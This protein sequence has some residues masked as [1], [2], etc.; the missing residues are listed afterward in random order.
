MIYGLLLKV[1][2]TSEGRVTVLD[3]Q[4]FSNGGA[5]VDL[6]IGVRDVSLSKFQYS[7]TPLHRCVG[8][9]QSNNS[10]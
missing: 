8:S 7:V 5:S 6:S 9:R 1:G 3:L 2:F 10:C 4:L